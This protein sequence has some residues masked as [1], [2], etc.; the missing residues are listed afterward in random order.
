MDEL[1]VSEHIALTSRLRFRAAGNEGVLVH[2]DTAQVIVVNDVGLHIIQSLQQ[3]IT[4]QALVDS[5]VSEFQVGQP[6]AQRD[7]EHYLQELAAQQMLVAPS[8]ASGN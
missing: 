5:I 4:R 7:L 6:E 1:Q 3:P 8:S 2:L